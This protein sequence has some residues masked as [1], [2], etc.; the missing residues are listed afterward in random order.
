MCLCV[1]SDA[2]FHMPF[3]FMFVC[4]SAVPALIFF[5]EHVVVPLNLS[6]FDLLLRQ[7]LLA[8]LEQAVKVSPSF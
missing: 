3:F 1:D 5:F 4:L 8:L 6:S 2:I 7:H